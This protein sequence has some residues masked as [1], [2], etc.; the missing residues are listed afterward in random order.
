MGGQRGQDCKS[1][2]ASLRDAASH[3]SH[4]SSLG[5]HKHRATNSHKTHWVR[6]P[7]WVCSHT[8]TTEH[9]LL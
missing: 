8:P 2:P 9:P 4:V 7:S 3:Y 6:L 1:I 5:S